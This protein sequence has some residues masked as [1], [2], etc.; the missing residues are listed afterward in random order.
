[1]GRREKKK[2]EELEEDLNDAREE[3]VIGL[4]RLRWEAWMDER[5]R[6]EVER[7]MAARQE[8]VKAKTRTAKTEQELSETVH[9]G[10]KQGVRHEIEAAQLEHLRVH[11]QEAYNPQLASRIMPQ[12]VSGVPNHDE[13]IEATPVMSQGSLGVPM[14]IH[15]SDEEINQEAFQVLM[16]IG[17]GELTEP[18]L[19]TYQKELTKRYPPLVVAE[20]MS[21]AQGLIDSSLT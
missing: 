21:R 18:E 11:S 15:I 1:M 16:K 20:I 2:I 14:S 7:K 4:L 3:G 12:L 6:K 19:P 13:I 17:T 9:D 10:T 5:L 8:L